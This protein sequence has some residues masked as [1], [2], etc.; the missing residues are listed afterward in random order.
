[1]TK[2]YR[3]IEPEVIY[4]YL[5]SPVGAISGIFMKKLHLETKNES[6]THCY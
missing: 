1:M 6:Y 5:A 3:K 4:L 2:K